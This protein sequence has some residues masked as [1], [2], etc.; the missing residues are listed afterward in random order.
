MCTLGFFYSP[1]PLRIY[2]WYK[3][4]EGEG[5]KLTLLEQV[6]I[7]ALFMQYCWQKY[8]EKYRT[9]FI[10]TIGMWEAGVSQ[11][12]ETEMHWQ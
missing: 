11:F 10:V 7:L 1:Q 2:I 9:Y 3:N 12:Q 4:Q 6:N 8:N 5:K